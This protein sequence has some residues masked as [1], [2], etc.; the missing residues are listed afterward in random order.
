MGVI[1]IIDCAR[2]GIPSRPLQYNID[3]Q[4]QVAVHTCGFDGIRRDYYLR[5]EP[6]GRAEIEVRMWKLKNG[7]P[8][9][10]EEIT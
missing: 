2:G 6:I 4:V 1:P 8:K 10:G 7:K 5:G 3:T 9:G